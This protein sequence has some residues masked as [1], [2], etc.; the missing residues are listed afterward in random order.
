MVLRAYERGPLGGVGT[1]T[2]EPHRVAAI[3]LW[4]C[5]AAIGSPC[6]PTGT[7]PIRGS[8]WGRSTSRRRSSS[9]FLCVVSFFV[10]AAQPGAGS[11]RSSCRQTRS[12][13]GE[14]WRLVT[15]PLAN[16]ADDLDRHRHRH[17]LVLRQSDRGPARPGRATCGCCVL[18]TVLPGLVATLVDVDVGMASAR[19][20]SRSSS[21][22]RARTRRCRSSSVSRR[23]SSRVVI[24][25]IE[26]LQLLGD[27]QSEVLIVYL[28]ALVTAVWTARSFGMLNDFQWLPQIKLPEAAARPLR[29]GGVA[30][31]GRPARSSSTGR[32]RRRRSTSR[33]RIRPRSTRSSTRSRSSAWT[34]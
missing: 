29:P 21:C 15:W 7:A 22:S 20:R 16:D 13:S 14:V 2:S 19:S 24:V 33:C 10:Y 3:G 27:R 9:S 32:G 6:R 26:I 25:G 34:G 30:I 31:V 28:A 5:L 17:L 1:T 12:R 4:R 18:I 8:G 11:S 23:G